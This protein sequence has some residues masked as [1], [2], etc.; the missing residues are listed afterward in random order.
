[1]Y[2]Q[3]SPPFNLDL[4]SAVVS[5]VDLVDCAWKSI[6]QRLGSSSRLPYITV[7]LDVFA[8]SVSSHSELLMILPPQ[9][10]FERFV[11]SSL[12]FLTAFRTGNL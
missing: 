6:T 11:H 10:N 12:R 1:M 4:P 8:S 5:V 9:I 2:S 3:F 7:I